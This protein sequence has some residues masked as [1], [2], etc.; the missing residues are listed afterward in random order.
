MSIKRFFVV[1]I[2]MAGIMFYASCEGESQNTEQEYHGNNQM[3]HH[4]D[5]NNHEEMPEDGHDNEPSEFIPSYTGDLPVENA[6]AILSGYLII[7]SGLVASDALI[8]KDGALQLLS[9]LAEVTSLDTTLAAIKEDAEHISETGAVSHQRDHFNSLSKNVAAVVVATNANHS[10][11]FLQYCP[12]AFDGKGAYWLS[13]SDEI[14][15][16]YFGDEMLKCGKVVE[17]IK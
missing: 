1:L 3:E 2:T 14:R 8:A 11:V 6:K 16:P 5:G 7:K 12:M 17:T 4:H 9:A 10:G 13:A 15:N